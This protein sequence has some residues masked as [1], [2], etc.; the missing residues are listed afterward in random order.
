MWGWGGDWGDERKPECEDKFG[1]KM[2]VGNCS[3]STLGQPP[4]CLSAPSCTLGAKFPL[5]NVLA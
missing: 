2:L 1:P 4:V 5:G 3:E